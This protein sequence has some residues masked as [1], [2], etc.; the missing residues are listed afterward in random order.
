M[1]K[2]H[3]TKD[4]SVHVYETGP[5]GKI[6]LHALCNF[7]QDIASDH[8]EKLGFG[9]EDLL[10]ENQFWVLS[11]LAVEMYKW[12][13]WG[14]DVS[15]RTW[16]RGTER[17]FSLRDFE[18]ISRDGSRIAA[19]SSSWL[20]LDLDTKRIKRPGTLITRYNYDYVPD[21]VLGRN[22]LKIESPGDNLVTSNI[23]KVSMSELDVNR[24]VN[25]VTY[26]KWATDVYDLDF[27]L[28]HQPV[29]A[30]IN[31]IAESRLYDEIGVKTEALDP[32][33][34]SFFHSVSRIS[35]NTEL[36]RIKIDWK[37]CSQ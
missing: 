21:G 19:A 4:Y 34:T 24:H 1:E 15:I 18:I 5:D 31:Y 28:S 29:S 13:E 37:N 3:F 16:T 33:K 22:A 9:K 7:L 23:L 27:R 12:P 11:R 6:T 32:L 35:D 20:M 30:E 25:N 2:L 36:C 14:S 17:I 26:I 8:A 10:R